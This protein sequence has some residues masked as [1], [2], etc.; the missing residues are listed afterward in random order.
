MVLSRVR[1]SFFVFIFL[2]EVNGILNSLFFLFVGTAG[3]GSASYLVGNS[4]AKSP[5]DTPV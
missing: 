4:F 3:Y 2:T 1:F 5:I